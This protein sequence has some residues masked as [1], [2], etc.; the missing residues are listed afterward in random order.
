MGQIAIGGGVECIAFQRVIA[1]SVGINCPSTNERR[2]QLLG[3]SGL[4]VENADTCWTTHLVP[5]EGEEIAPDALNVHGKVRNRLTRVNQVK[6]AP[7]IADFPNSFDRADRTERIRHVGQSYQTRFVS[8]ELFQHSQVERTIWIS[9][10]PT[11]GDPNLFGQAQ[12]G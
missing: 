6:N 9:N 4:E 8:Q 1:R 2:Y 10:P 12:P 3:K 7:L 11:H 5:G